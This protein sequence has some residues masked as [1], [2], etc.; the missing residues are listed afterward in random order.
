MDSFKKMSKENKWHF[1]IITSILVSSILI[2][3]FVGQNEAWF[4]ERNFTAGYMSGSLLAAVLLFGL[5][6]SV[7]FF[8]EKNP[9]SE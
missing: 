6:R 1:F 5:Y 4:I 9:K 8:I 2:G 3:I 7:A